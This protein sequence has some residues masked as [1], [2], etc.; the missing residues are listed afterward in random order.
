MDI[1]Y[2]ILEVHGDYKVIDIIEKGSDRDFILEPVSGVVNLSLSNSD[3]NRIQFTNVRRILI[4][5]ALLGENSY[6][7]VHFLSDTDLFS[8]MVN[9]DVDITLNSIAIVYTGSGMEFRIE[10]K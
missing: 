2:G 6:S 5:A 7:S 4:R 10:K 9:F 8:S 1:K 3:I